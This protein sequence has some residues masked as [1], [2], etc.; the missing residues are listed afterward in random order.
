MEYQFTTILV[1]INEGVG[2]V[3]LNRPERMN[4]MTLTMGEELLQAFTQMR[5]DS[6]VKVVM[7]TGA[8]RGFCAGADTDTL[9][10]ETRLDFK[11]GRHVGQEVRSIVEI[12]KPVIAA[13]NGHAVGAGAGLALNCDVIFASE[14]AKFSEIF[15]QVGVFPDFGNLWQLPRLV[16]PHKAKQL[17]FSAEIIDAQEMFRLGIAQAIFPVEEL[18]P[19]TLEFC[20]RL[21]KGPT[22]SY[23]L[24]KAFIDRGWGMS[25]E[26]FLDY[27]ALG[28]QIINSSEDAKEGI[29]AFLEKRQPAY[30]GR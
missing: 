25:L 17:C 11:F 30:K 16:G 8:G 28:I 20:K 27:E 7:I 6:E 1:E 2:V 24:S 14:K 21:G 29:A 3:T 26:Q 22:L 15:A 18:I 19:K 10:H 12:E 4:A 9:S 13:V 23:M 5:S